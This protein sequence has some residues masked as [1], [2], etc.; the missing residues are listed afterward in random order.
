MADYMN[1]CSKCGRMCFTMSRDGKE[2]CIDC[3][4]RLAKEHQRGSAQGR[5]LRAVLLICSLAI[6]FVP[7]YVLYQSIPDSTSTSSPRRTSAPTSSPTATAPSNHHIAWSEYY[8]LKNMPDDVTLDVVETSTSMGEVY[9][10]IACNMDTMWD[11]EAY[12]KAAAELITGVIPGIRDKV[13]FD[14]V[15]FLFYGPFVD[16][17]GNSVDQLGI[18]AMYSRDT[19]S[20]INVDYF[21]SRRYSDPEAVIQVADTYFIHRAYQD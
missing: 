8:V 1:K 10:T 6:V 7:L 16:K 5:F 19:L 15:T 3:A 2:Y 13:G 21:R 11:G 12:V 18:R 20:K 4:T 17:Y 14:H 9:L